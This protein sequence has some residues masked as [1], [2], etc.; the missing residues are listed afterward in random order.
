MKKPPE[1]PEAEI[2]GDRSPECPS[3]ET[4]SAAKIKSCDARKML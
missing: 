2:N 3:N 4:C 1:I